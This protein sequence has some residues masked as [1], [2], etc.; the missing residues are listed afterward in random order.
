MISDKTKAAIL[1]KCCQK[2]DCLARGEVI[3]LEGALD[4]S[5]TSP[6]TETLNQRALQFRLGVRRLF[7]EDGPNKGDMWFFELWHFLGDVQ[8]ALGLAQRP[9]GGV[10]AEI[11]SERAR[12][13]EVKGY[14]AAHDD[15]HNNGAIAEA[16]ACYASRFNLLVMDPR[17]IR[18]RRLWPWEG[19]PKGTRRQQLV[20]SAAL[21]VAEIERLDRAVSHS[22]TL[23]KSENSK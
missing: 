1:D 18:P 15:A 14:D 12:Q 17:S 11:G 23:C 7:E 6:D 21:I 19:A 20:K 9:A 2:V 4:A 13:I 8:D 10:L 16:A 5:Q 3:D 22:L